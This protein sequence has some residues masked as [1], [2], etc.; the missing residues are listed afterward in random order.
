MRLGED[1]FKAM[2]GGTRR[3]FHRHVEFPALVRLGLAE[4]TGKDV[5]EVGCGNGFGAE[6]ISALRPRSYAG[7][8]L[9]PEQ[10]RLAE[11]RGL[12]GARFFVGDATAID[13][14]AGCAD[15]VVV[16]GVLHHIEDWPRAVSECRR[17]LRPTGVLVLEEPDAALLRGWDRV[18]HWDH[19]RAGFSLRGLEQELNAGGLRVERRVVLPGAFGAYRARRVG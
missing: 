16:F 10:V 9:M 19:P 5:V 11:R 4:A 18:F 1:E 6:L 17:I 14:P 12:E 3:F 2:S 7:F 13:L 15:V 8:D